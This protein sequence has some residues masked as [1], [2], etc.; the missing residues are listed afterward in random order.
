[1]FSGISRQINP[2]YLV[3]LTLFN[4]AIAMN[5]NWIIWN[6]LY[7]I[8]GVS[9]LLINLFYIQYWGV[10]IFNIALS[11]YA[12]LPHFPRMANHCNIELVVELIILGLV[13]RRLFGAKISISTHLVSIVFRVS[14]VSIYFYSGLHK[15]N[16]DFFNPCVS[17]VNTVH[18]RFI[19]NFT[20]V[21]T[22]LSDDF[23]SVLQYAT[24]V[25]EMI[26]P[27]GLFW[28]VTRKYSVIILLVFHGY[29]SLTYY[30]DFSSL[31]LFLIIG[32]IINFD[33]T[34]QNPIKIAALRFY[35]GFCCVTLL[36]N[37]IT[38]QNY[39]LADDRYFVTG[40]TYAIGYFAFALFFINKYTP[41]KT[42][43]LSKK[44]IVIV[45]LVVLCISGWALKAYA[46][47]GNV[48][49][50]TMFS[51]LVTEK[52]QNNHLIIDTNKTKL[53][54]YEEDSVHIL[55]LH[56]TLA[57]Q[58]VTNYKLPLIEFQY[59]ADN[60]VKTYTVPL[61]VTV[62]YK[63]DTLVIPDLKNSDFSKSKWYY[64]YL[65]FRKMPAEGPNPCLW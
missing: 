31:G 35:V 36:V 49:N 9:L 65:N 46:G 8:I 61:N 21:I 42:P 58:F 28:S 64:K 17:C 52:S 22:T 53:F 60:W 27:F 41:Q 13:L 11:L 29:L 3:L 45:S 43:S 33:N 57:S 32:S 48:G 40:I 38:H 34:V 55:Q 56:D 26:I 5:H 20:G 10:V 19:Y 39:L 2:N 7:S 50:F 54:D 14:L 62:I 47:L 44:L 6:N 25:T 12:L 24:I 59:R 30:F 18:E 37:S 4:C 16:S 23:S 51:N 1:M 15:L 63:N